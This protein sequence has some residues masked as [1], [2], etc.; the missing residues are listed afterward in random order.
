VALRGEPTGSCRAWCGDAI[1]VAKRTLKAG[2]TLDGEGGYTVYAKL[3]PAARSLGLGALPIGL[4]HHVKL[5][6]NVAAGEILT[7][8]D[9][10]LDETSPVVRIRREMRREAWQATEVLAADMA[11]DHGAAAG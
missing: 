3:I 6:R 9:V 10:A 8:A 4:A 11:A 7:A 1:A 2:E 5:L